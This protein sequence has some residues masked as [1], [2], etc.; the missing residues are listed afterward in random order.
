MTTNTALTV[1]RKV[2]FS[3]SHECTNNDILQFSYLLLSYLFMEKYFS[4]EL[5]GFSYAKLCGIVTAGLFTS[6]KFDSPIIGGRAIHSDICNY[7]P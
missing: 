3:I 6:R 5:T 7:N 2:R 1:T 4:V